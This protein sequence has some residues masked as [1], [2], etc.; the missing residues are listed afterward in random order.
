MKERSVYNQKFGIIL[1]E[2]EKLKPEVRIQVDRINNEISSTAALQSSVDR[3]YEWPP[4]SMSQTK[5]FGSGKLSLD[6]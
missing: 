4:I 6:G 5:V 3:H 2:L 1:A